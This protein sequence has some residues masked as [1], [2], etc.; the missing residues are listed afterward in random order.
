[1]PA[2]RS[3]SRSAAPRPA[4]RVLAACLSWLA[5]SAALA[6]PAAPPPDA[7]LEPPPARCA[8]GPSRADYVSL[9]AASASALAVAVAHCRS[10]GYRRSGGVARAVVDNPG[11]SSPELYFQVMVVPPGAAASAASSPARAPGG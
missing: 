11:A 2:S 4:R 9:R 8:S 5:W 10:L 1:M 6:A 3:A 7:T